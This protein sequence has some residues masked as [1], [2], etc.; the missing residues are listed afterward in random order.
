MNSA[1][2]LGKLGMTFFLVDLRL[3]V[4]GCLV[5]AVFFFA[6][7]FIHSERCK[8]QTSKV[9]NCQL[10]LGNDLGSESWLSNPEW[11]NSCQQPH[12]FGH[13]TMINWWQNRGKAALSSLASLTYELSIF[14]ILS[15]GTFV[16]RISTNNSFGSVI[17]PTWLLIKQSNKNLTAYITYD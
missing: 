15:M 12:F 4:R 13:A 17:S 9:N 1:R 11:G 6:F 7:H 5:N 16:N 8:W 2:F 14:I 3:L 10:K